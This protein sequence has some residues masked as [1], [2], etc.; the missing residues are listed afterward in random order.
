[1]RMFDNYAEALATFENEVYVPSAEERAE[2]E[3]H[4]QAAR[5]WNERG[6]KALWDTDGF[7]LTAFVAGPA[8]EDERAKAERIRNGGR[9]VFLVFVRLSDDAIVA[10]EPERLQHPVHHWRHERKW[11]VRNERGRMQRDEEGRWMVYPVAPKRTKQAHESRGYA[12]R[13]VILPYRLVDRA[14]AIGDAMKRGLACAQLERRPILPD[15]E[16]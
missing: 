6:N 8:A 11:V 15:A 4:E 12:E 10:T 16:S 13:Y 9:G 1:M 2:I 7:S 5:D 3:A 14:E